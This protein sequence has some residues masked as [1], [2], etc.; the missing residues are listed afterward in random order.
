MVNSYSEPPVL[1]TVSNAVFNNGMHTASN[2]SVIELEPLNSIW[3]TEITL[4]VEWELS[5]VG[6]SGIMV[7]TTYGQSMSVPITVLLN[8]QTAGEYIINPTIITN[9]S[10]VKI[11]SPIYLIKN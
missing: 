2:S 8:G 10:S 5:K 4:A 1:K 7:I 3:P 9:F 6:E 11:L